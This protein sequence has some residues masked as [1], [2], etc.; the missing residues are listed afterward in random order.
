M[1]GYAGLCGTRRIWQLYREAFAGLFRPAFTRELERPEGTPA[2]ADIRLA[3]WLEEARKEPE[4]PFSAWQWAGD[5]GVLAALWE[6]SGVHGVGLDIDLR[7]IPLRQITVELCE[8]LELNPYR[9]QS[10]GVLL[11]AADRGGEAARALWA[12]GIPA[13]VIGFIPR[14]TDRRIRHGAEEAGY[15]ERPQP[16]ELQRLEERIK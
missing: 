1:A 7:S 16:D 3:R 14:G 11:L 9:L 15:L 10:D 5:G 6:L 4:R 2:D 12:A 13:A 8:R